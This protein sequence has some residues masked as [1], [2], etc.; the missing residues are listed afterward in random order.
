MAQSLF[1]LLLSVL[2]VGSLAAWSF[3]TEVSTVGI[4]TLWYVLGVFVMIIAGFLSLWVRMKVIWVAV[5]ARKKR[6]CLWFKSCVFVFNSWRQFIGLQ[7]MEKAKLEEEMLR[8]NDLFVPSHWDARD[9]MND[10]AW[11]THWIQ[12]VLKSILGKRYVQF[13]LYKM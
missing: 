13:Y 9:T 3:L 6:E 2:L 8:Q 12:G 11:I 7:R 5:L 1:A 10:T 4:Q